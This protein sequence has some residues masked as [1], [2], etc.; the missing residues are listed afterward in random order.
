MAQLAR[1]SKDE[2]KASQRIS[3]SH[4][5]VKTKSPS[6]HLSKS[7]LN[8]KSNKFINVAKSILTI[9]VHTG[10]SRI[11]TELSAPHKNF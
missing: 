2:I 6:R 3:L 5:K 8:Y 11:L 10:G 1:N 7:N 4:K 9:V